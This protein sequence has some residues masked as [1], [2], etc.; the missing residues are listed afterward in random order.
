MKDGFKRLKING[1]GTSPWAGRRRGMSSGV[2]SAQDASGREEVAAGGALDAWSARGG[3]PRRCG[4]PAGE[5][6]RWRPT[7]VTVSVFQ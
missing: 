3:D 5:K 7:A 4:D 1:G 2:V 6:P